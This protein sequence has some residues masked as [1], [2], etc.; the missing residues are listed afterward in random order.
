MS[1]L[2][3]FWLV[4]VA[5]LALTTPAAAA[6]TW[7]VDLTSAT[8][9]IDAHA[10]ADNG[11]NGLR[12]LGIFY[13]DIGSATVADFQ[14]S[15]LA[16]FFGQPAEVF[17]LGATVNLIGEDS[18][19]NPLFRTSASTVGVIGIKGIG[20]R[21]LDIYWRA[22]TANTQR[23]FQDEFY[24]D[25]MARLVA[26]IVTTIDGVAPGT[27]LTIGYDWEYLGAAVIDHEGLLE[28]PTRASGDL[29]FF[30]EQGSGP[31]NLF[32]ENF[33]E[34]GPLAG[35][36]GNSGSYDL[37]TSNTADP[38]FLT[39]DLNGFSETFMNF[40]GV[41]PAGALQD[42]QASSVFNGR[43]TLTLPVPEP[44][45]FTLCLV[46]GALMPFARRLKVSH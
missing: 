24:S 43:L 31:G 33:A 21:T 35:A 26:Q 25:S 19:I 38:S 39:I 27:T 23:D 2:L 13:E 37:T 29:S 41:P 28:D 15:L 20:T 5:I 4:S 36:G 8:L 16:S 30:D 32:N 17:D 14:A 7:G 22:N 12:P 1:S 18:G 3:R 42:D 40:P 44:T 10:Y 6:P 46:C 9:Q 34:P 45:T 11:V